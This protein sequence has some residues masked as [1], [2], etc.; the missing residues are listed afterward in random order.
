MRTNR[1]GRIP[2]AIVLILA[3][4]PPAKHASAEDTLESVLERMK[5]SSAVRIAYRETRYLELLAQ[6]WN[7]SGYFYSLPPGV[8][9][10][11]QYYPAR[12][13]MAADDG[14]LYYYDPV[15]DVRRRGEME[16]GGPMALHLAAFKALI[17][18]DGRLMEQLYRISFAARAETWE[19]ALSPREKIDPVVDILISGPAGQGAERIVVRQGDG[20]RSEYR[21]SNDGE[22]KAMEKKIAGLRKE[23]LGD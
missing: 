4:V 16:D 5:P 11:E 10:K 8:M 21:L 22:G 15:N 18:G 2:A 14:R 7:G 19:I 6:P 9:I 12:E 17:G 23:L 3:L 20:D 1:L 13:I